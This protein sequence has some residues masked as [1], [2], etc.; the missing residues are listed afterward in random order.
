MH[1][2]LLVIVVAGFLP[3][4]TLGDV[5]NSTL[6]ASSPPVLNIATN[7]EPRTLRLKVTCRSGEVVTLDEAT[8]VEQ[9][10]RKAGFIPP[11]RLSMLDGGTVSISWDDI[12]KIVVGDK[13]PFENTNPIEITLRNVKETK[14]GKTHG[15]HNTILGRSNAGE[16]SIE[17][18][19]VLEII[20]LSPPE[21]N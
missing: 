7:Q 17:L 16:F 14:V 2:K 9:G 4:I 20:V 1:R 13:V 15:T 19:D 11:V 21:K 8:F 5:T 10:I 12:E 6:S 3:L 18:K